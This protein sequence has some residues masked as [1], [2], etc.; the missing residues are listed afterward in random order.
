LLDWKAEVG[1]PDMSIS[2]DEIS[3]VLAMLDL[4]GCVEYSQKEEFASQ[5]EV[6]QR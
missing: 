4:L 6:I 3:Y 1:C 2:A 5:S